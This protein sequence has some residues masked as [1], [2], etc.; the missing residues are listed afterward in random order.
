MEES[1]KKREGGKA[2]NKVDIFTIPFSLEAFK[3]NTS[4]T[5]NSASKT[6][7][8]KII[9]QAYEFHS[10]GNL[11]KAAKYY[12]YFIDQGFK[13]QIVFCNYGVILQ[14]LGKLQEAELSQRKAIELNPNFADAYSNLGNILR[15]L[16]KLKE[17][18]LST[19][20][21][22]ELD[23][24]LPEAHCN[25]GTI[26]KDLGK[27]QEAELSQRRAIKLKPNY[28]L[29]HSNLG[30]VLKDLGKLQEA[31]LSQRKAIELKPDFATAHC[32]LGSILI[33]LGNFKEAEISSRKAIELNPGYARA[34]S[35]LGTVL[36]NL[37]NLKQGEFLQ[38][39]AIELKPNFAEAHCNLGNILSDL[40]NLKEAEISTRKSIELNPNYALAHSNLGSILKDLGKLKKAEIST[41]KAIKLKP[42]YAESNYNL[43]SILKDL[44]KLQ[45]AEISTRKA[46][47]L[48][49]NFSEAYS[50]L[51]NILRDLDQLQDAEISTRKAIELN[52]DFAEAYMNLGEILKDFGNIKE[53]ESS[54]R[55]AIKLNPRSEEAKLNL[56]LILL[57]TSNFKEGLENYE[58][59]WKRKGVKKPFFTFTPEWTPNTK[60]KVLLWDEQG[61]GD[62]IL[63]ASLI[64][65]LVK[66]VDQLF[67]QVDERLIP[68]FRRSFDRSIIYVHRNQILD[69][70][71]YD[72]QIPMGSLIKHLRTDKESFEN[73]KRIYLKVNKSES[74][75]FKEKLRDSEHE[76]IIGISWK[77]TSKRDKAINLSLEKL[78]LGIYSPKI[79]FLCLQYGDVE[80]EIIKL[81]N[82]HRIKIETIPELDLFNNIDGLA[83]LIS[84]C[85]EIVS[86]D[87]VTLHLA[88]AIGIKTNI[89]LEHNCCWYHGINDKKSYWFSNVNYFRQKN[90]NEW[91]VPLKEIKDAIKI[92]NIKSC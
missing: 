87:N 60:G 78:L 77:S 19:D 69:E 71:K 58:F 27:L 20:K 67:V 74:T 32:N 52:P 5:T 80:K 79:K 73:S 14:N 86:I 54:A 16:G 44:G 70:N 56:S 41:R 15:E 43:G 61:I 62:K 90:F 88:G 23:P 31:E 29:A 76:K 89:L 81:R 9:N 91:D 53:A 13:D 37:G 49:P 65:E 4:I 1:D 72:F 39:K 7:K 55:K 2:L 24:N 25:L 48:N 11:T 85:D 36:R 83:S 33:D 6:S 40:G 26:L 68:L 50:N 66:K 38:R 3:R 47:E 75:I 82:K 84:A 8:E 18:K 34:Y 21:A 46:I 12:Q 17:A 64:P 45:D 57:K 59:R 22:I 42:D 10:Q 35:N 92:N 30:N 51:G 63:L 28:A